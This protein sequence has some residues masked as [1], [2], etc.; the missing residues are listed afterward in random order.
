MVGVELPTNALLGYSWLRLSA[1]IA[2]DYL[3]IDRD[4]GREQA[5]RTTLEPIKALAEAGTQ[6]ALSTP[7]RDLGRPGGLPPGDELVA[8]HPAGT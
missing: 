4:R 8:A 5:I 3:M 1:R 7:N 2:S 6:Q